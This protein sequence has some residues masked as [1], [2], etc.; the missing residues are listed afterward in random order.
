MITCDLNCDMGEGVG[1]DAAIIPYITSAN[2]ACGYQAGDVA[3]MRET[4]LLAQ[5]N[6]VAIG[7]HP[8]F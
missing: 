1:N 6:S 5:K 4:V 8:P 7:A 3:I 2:I